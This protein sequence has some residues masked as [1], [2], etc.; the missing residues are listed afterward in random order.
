MSEE[1]PGEVGKQLSYKLGV[2]RID[3]TLDGVD[4]GTNLLVT[5]SGVDKDSFVHGSVSRGIEDDETVI[6]VT[7]GESAEDVLRSY[8]GHDLDRLAVVDC[9]SENQ[10]LGEVEG[11]ES[12]RTAGSPSDMTGI[13]IE[14]SELLEASWGDK[15]IERN[16]VCVDSVSTLLMYADLETVFRFLHVF[17]GRIRSVDGLG[18][19]AMD[20][21]MHDERENSTLRQLFDGSVEF[22]DGS[23]R[24][25]GLT[26]E[27][28]GWVELD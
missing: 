10:D 17:T 27:P 16:R 5:G 13:G 22:D 20:P 21:G 8:D 28:T 4:G 1:K 26:D 25:T 15:G 3:E 19:F 12:V 6:Y 14:V 9:V 7:T 24:V 23:V 11:N 2:P 18:L